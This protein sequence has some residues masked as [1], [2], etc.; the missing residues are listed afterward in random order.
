MTA[1]AAR[2]LEPRFSHLGFD[3]C[4]GLLRRYE[5]GLQPRI[6]QNPC[7]LA[8]LPR[9]PRVVPR[10]FEKAEYHS[11]KA[12]GLSST[13]SA[14]ATSLSAFFLCSHHRWISAS[15]KQGHLAYLSDAHI[16]EVVIQHFYPHSGAGGVP[17]EVEAVD[18]AW[19]WCVL[20]GE[21]ILRSTPLASSGKFYH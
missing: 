20:R 10:V 19:S 9:G 18:A 5:S 16:G 15:G 2:G 1:V 17:G 14:G 8:V 13:S 11:S 7:G 3:G 6:R 12:V 4:D 21:L